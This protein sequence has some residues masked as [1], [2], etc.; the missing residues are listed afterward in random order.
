MKLRNIT[1]GFA[2]AAT[3]AVTAMAVMELQRRQA[4]EAVQNMPIDIGGPF[5]MTAHDGT[6]VTEE[7]L[8]GRRALIFFGFTFCPDVCPTTLNE[9]AAWLDELGEDGE[10]IDPYFVSVDPAR[11]TP[12]R[13]AEYAGY[14]SPRITGLV[15]TEEQLAAMASSY[16]VYYARIDL[17]DGDYLMDHSAAVY[18]MD[19]DGRFYDAITHTATFEEAVAKLR[20]LVENG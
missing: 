1:I 10:L 11:D 6:P 16:K 4:F 17:D 15:G 3:I 19:G 12:E 20:L 13:M 5:T 2:A 7:S 8:K 18:L 14:F 9:V